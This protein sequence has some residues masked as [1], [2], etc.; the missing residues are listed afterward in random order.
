MKIENN[1]PK[2]YNPP[3][4]GFNVE[5]EF[6]GDSALPYDV[7]FLPLEHGEVGDDLLFNVSNDCNKINKNV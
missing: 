2:F 3:I 7:A 1:D 6:E 5:Y 4:K